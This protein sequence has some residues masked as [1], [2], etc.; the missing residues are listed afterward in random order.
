MTPNTQFL[1]PV[2][3]QEIEIGKPM[4]WAVYDADHNLLL[5]YGVVITTEHQVEVLVEK[6]L[7][8]E[9][10]RRVAA[11]PIT[12]PASDKPARPAPRPWRPANRSTRSS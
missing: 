10:P 1:V 11:A 2:K 5:N 6:G 4:P 7:F 9:Q 3:K 8:R 12:R